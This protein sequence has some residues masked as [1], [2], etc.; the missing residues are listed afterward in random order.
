[1]TNLLPQNE[2]IEEDINCAAAAV[3]RPNSAHWVNQNCRVV[4]WPCTPN[5]A[6]EDRQRTSDARCQVERMSQSLTKSIDAPNNVTEKVLGSG[7]TVPLEFSEAT[8]F[9]FARL[10]FA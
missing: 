9:C 3:A 1:M 10:D 8:P 5:Y 7:V 6:P 4:K 2:L